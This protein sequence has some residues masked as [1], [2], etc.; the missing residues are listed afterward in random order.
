M[1]RYSVAFLALSLGAAASADT[2]MKVRYS[3]SGE[4]SETLVYSKGPRQRMEYPG[5]IVIQ[6]P[7]LNRFLEVDAAAKTYLVVPIN[8]AA[9][10]VPGAAA[11]RGGV[12]RV[13]T[14]ST[15]TG[16]TKPMLGRQAR[17]VKT[18]TVEQPMPGACDSTPR[19]IEM[20]G[21]YVDVPVGQSNPA[22]HSSAGAQVTCQDQYQVQTQ[23]EPASGLAVAYTMTLR[24][25]NKTT[26][27]SM[28]VLELATDPLDASLFE[29]PAGYQAAGGLADFSQ[30]QA[31]AA[32]AAAPAKAA[33]AVRIGLLGIADTSGR[34]LDG[35]YLT[36]QLR[37]TLVSSGS[38]VVRV[39]SA[40]E[41]TA[42][43]CD[44]LL[45]GQ[46]TSLK[47]NAIG[48]VAGQAAKV[49]GLLRGGFGR[50]AAAPAPPPD[51]QVEAHVEYRMTALAGNK[52]ETTG[53]ATA[54]TG[55]IISLRTA[56]SLA[57]NLTPMLMMAQMYQS[58]YSM[59][60][61]NQA[62]AAQQQQSTM[63]PAMSGINS[64]S[65]AS[66]ALASQTAPPPSEGRAIGAAFEQLAKGIAA[67]V[68]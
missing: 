36:E 60:M 54:K 68:K 20:D 5:T 2:K 66:S 38:D 49:G 7:D 33:G 34:A 31:K 13:T 16:E 15:N 43:H 63:D 46:V 42:A 10:A 62:M 3:S 47:K 27:T 23:G 14:T 50:G 32:T 26:A 44:Y 52:A 35:N 24:E 53:S 67:A 56:M 19:T 51:E 64:W 4:T 28:E 25:G 21:W 12:V 17:H 37:K 22:E 45:T 55:S 6:Q 61:M 11:K 29:A 18:V 58:M 8:A 1:R 30:L 57:S 59:Q 40:D 41:A 9:P 39:F 65:M 48:Q